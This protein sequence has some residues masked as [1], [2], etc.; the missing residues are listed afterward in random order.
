MF[1]GGVGRGL[2]RGGEGRSDPLGEAVEGVEVG[3]L[4]WGVL[5][6]TVGCLFLR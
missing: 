4:G 2:N 5:V 1:V 3:Q 6:D